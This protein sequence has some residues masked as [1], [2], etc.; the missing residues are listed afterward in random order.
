MS[1]FGRHKYKDYTVVSNLP[2]EELVDM[3]PTQPKIIKIKTMQDAIKL[4]NAKSIDDP[5]RRLER[6]RKVAI[7]K[8]KIFAKQNKN[9][10]T[11]SPSQPPPSDSRTSR[12]DAEWNA[13][14]REQM[15]AKSKIDLDEE[16][17]PSEKKET[18]AA[19]AQ[20]KQRAQPSSSLGAR[21]LTD[22]EQVNL[23]M[24]QLAHETRLERMEEA[25]K[26]AEEEDFERRLK[27]LGVRDLTKKG[28]RDKDNVKRKYSYK[29]SKLGKKRKTNRRNKKM[30]TQR[31]Y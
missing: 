31:K 21:S 17:F 24:Q 5:E 29:K 10:E 4:L 20:P 16:L 28:G 26:K 14:V 12:R 8:S 9:Q 22:E 1:I 19:M 3:D 13:A 23:L 11:A 25:T 6:D 7:L 30:K 2:V 27:A 15:E 18:T